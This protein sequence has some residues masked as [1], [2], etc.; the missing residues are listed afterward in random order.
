MLVVDSTGNLLAVKVFETNRHG[1]PC[2]IELVGER[3]IAWE[4]NSRRLSGAYERLP[5]SSEAFIL[6]TSIA[7]LLKHPLCLN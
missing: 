5:Q 1:R 6:I 7:R 2:F 3:A 4:S